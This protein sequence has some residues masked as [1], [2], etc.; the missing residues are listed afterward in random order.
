MEYSCFHSIVKWKSL[1]KDWLYMMSR[2]VRLT[3]LVL[4]LLGG[5]ATLPRGDARSATASPAATTL[6]KHNFRRNEV[7]NYV[8]ENTEARYTT[9][10][11]NTT[12]RPT[13]LMS[14]EEIKVSVTVDILDSGAST[15]KR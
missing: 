9:K 13:D 3:P 12:S 14:I 8:F 2:C 4:T 6:A 15:T 11:I 1:S 7:F 10:A 5:C